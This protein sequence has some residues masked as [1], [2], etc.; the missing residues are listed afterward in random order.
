[1][2][3]MGED[4]GLPKL[5][6]VNERCDEGGAKQYVASAAIIAAAGLI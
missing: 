6:L 5:K 1:M 2:S 3:N 4:V